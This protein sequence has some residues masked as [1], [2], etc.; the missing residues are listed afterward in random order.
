MKDRD[1]SHKR[2]QNKFVISS[3]EEITSIS[4]EEYQKLIEEGILEDSESINEGDD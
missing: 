4:K 3:K 1:L 2:Q